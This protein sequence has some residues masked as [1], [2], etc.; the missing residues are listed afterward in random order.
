MR[1]LRFS[2]SWVLAFSVSLLTPMDGACPAQAD[3]S[4]QGESTAQSMDMD[5]HDHAEGTV[6]MMVPQ[7]ATSWAPHEM[8]GIANVECRRGQACR[9][10]RADSATGPCQ[11]Q[12]L[13]GCHG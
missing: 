8:D 13:S 11:V 5:H 3:E 10:D 7:L 1:H 4:V 9:S 12:R 6:D 2:L